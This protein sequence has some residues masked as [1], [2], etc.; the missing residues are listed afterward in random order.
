MESMS[1]E[2]VCGGVGR[3][4]IAAGCGRELGSTACAGRRGS[5]RMCASGLLALHRAPR[6]G[7]RAPGSVRTVVMATLLMLCFGMATDGFTAYLPSLQAEYGVSDLQ[8]SLLVTLRCVT[9]F[10]SALLA[11]SVYGRVTLRAGMTASVALLAAGFAACSLLIGRLG[12][13]AVVALVV[14]CGLGFPTATAG[15]SLW[16]SDLFP[17]RF[18]TFVQRLQV[19]YSFGTLAGM[20]LPGLVAGLTGSYVPIYASYAVCALVV[21]ALVQSRYRKAGMDLCRVAGQV[22]SP[23]TCSSSTR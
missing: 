13:A 20:P 10:A 17:H 6:R 12:P 3:G 9:S 4:A 7:R 18:D 22:A 5:A 19:A 16:V 8:M 23:Q 11:H 15:P 2:A 14:L 21:L 1:G